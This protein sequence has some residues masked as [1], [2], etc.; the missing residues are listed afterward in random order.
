MALTPGE[1]ESVIGVL[2]WHAER[3]ADAPFLVD[4][5]AAWTY[6]DVHA[7][8]K[9]RASAFAEMGVGR[10]DT[11]AFY[12]ENSAQQAISSFAVNM[13]GG[14]WSPANIDYRGEWLSSNL[15]DIASDVLVVDA[16]LLPRVN[17]L[18]DVSFKH[19]VVNG[20][21]DVPVAGGATP[22]DLVSL[23]GYSEFP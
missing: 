19:V 21:T 23:D 20:P 9:R 6:G 2:Q 4:E 12:M 7:L 8:A 22:H 14:I 17:E 10:G 16:H 3:R 1:P 5:T 13:L 18:S 15:S 11:V